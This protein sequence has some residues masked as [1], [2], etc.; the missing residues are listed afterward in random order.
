MGGTTGFH[1]PWAQDLTLAGF[2]RIGFAGFGHEAAHAQAGR[3]GRIRASGGVGGGMDAAAVARFDAGHAALPAARF[4][5]EPLRVP[6]RVFAIWGVR[7]D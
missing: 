6:H 1:P 7:P 3:R 5:D 2:A 4:P